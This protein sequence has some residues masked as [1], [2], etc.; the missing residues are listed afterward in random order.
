MIGMDKDESFQKEKEQS[1]T[2]LYIKIE[3]KNYD[4]D[5]IDDLVQKSV[6][7]MPD[8]VSHQ[9]FLKIFQKFFSKF[10]PLEL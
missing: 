10:R 8:H 4:I 9:S 1:I 7:I 2:L 3:R 5:K 6:E